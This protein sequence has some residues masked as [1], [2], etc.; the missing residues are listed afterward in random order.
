MFTI[1]IIGQKGGTGKTTVATGLSVAAAEAGRTVALLDLDPQT[2]AAN[3]RDRREADNPAVLP[4]PIGRLRQA[5]EAAIGA[6]ADFIVIDTPGKSDSVAIAA[7][8]IADVVL[9]PIAAQ[10]FGLETLQNVREL[11]GMAGSP[12]A[13]VLVNEMH[14]SATR[15]AEE[16]KAVVAEASGMRVCPIHLCSRDIYGSAPAEGKGP[17]EVEPHG[18]AADELRQL[19]KF[20]SALSD[21]S[22]GRTHDDQA[23]KVAE[24]AG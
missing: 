3:W 5:H 10:I 18:K 9:V 20:I 7:A 21:K 1:A 19:Y 4:V 14:P 24:R 13:F 12:L 17:T 8:K 23:R 15:L 6:G 22:E 2:N 11:I 16:A